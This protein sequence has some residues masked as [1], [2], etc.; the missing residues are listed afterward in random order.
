M[1]WDGEHC[2]PKTTGL[3]PIQS[4]CRKFLNCFKGRGHVQSCAPG[5]LFNS[6]SLECDFPAKVQ[7]SDGTPS[8][9]DSSYINR[10]PS[11]TFDLNA[12]NSDQ[13]QV[14]ISN[15]N[16]Y[17]PQ[18]SSNSLVGTQFIVGGQQSST[19]GYFQNFDSAVTID[20]GL[21]SGGSYPPLYGSSSVV[22]GYR[23][24]N[25]ESQS[26]QTS[27]FAANE[28][29]P[30]T[31]SQ[32]QQNPDFAVNG[33]SQPNSFVQPQQYPPI[34]NPDFSVNGH[35]QPNTF[36]QPQQY[37]DSTVNGY[38][39]S[40]TVLQHQQFSAEQNP[41]FFPQNT[42]NRQLN[43]N[44]PTNTR[45]VNSNS[46]YGG[47]TPTFPVGQTF[48]QNPQNTYPTGYVYSGKDSIPATLNSQSNNQNQNNESPNNYG[49]PNNYETPNNYG[50]SNNNG[51]VRENQNT[52]LNEQEQ[53]NQQKN[54]LRFPYPKGTAPISQTGYTANKPS[55]PS[56]INPNSWM[57]GQLKEKQ[58]LGHSSNSLNNKQSENEEFPSSNNQFNK[59]SSTFDLGNRQPT[60]NENRQIHTE[61]NY[62]SSI[63]TSQSYV[64]SEQLPYIPNG[65]G[66]NS[67]SPSP[68]NTAQNS[69]STPQDRRIHGDFK[70]NKQFKVI[71]PNITYPNN[72]NEPS[73]YQSNAKPP[74]E[75][76]FN[77]GSSG[78]KLSN[79]YGSVQN[80]N[81]NEKSSAIQNPIYIDQN[82][83]PSQETLAIY[84]SP[85][86]VSNCPNN[87]NG[88]KPHPTDCSK[89]LSCANGRTFEMNCGPGTLFNPT[90]SVCDHPYN[91][92]CNN[93]FINQDATTETTIPTQ[94]YTPVDNYTP[95]I[96]LRQQFNDQD[97]SSSVLVPKTAEPLESQAVLETLPNENKQLKVLRN[98]E[99]IDLVDNFLSN[100]SVIQTPSKTINNK[101][102]NNIAVRI[103]LKPNSTQS[104]RL[105]GGPK[106]SEGFLQIQE[107]PFQWGVVCDEPNS[108]TIDKADII[109]KQLGFK[110]Y[111]LF[112]LL[113]MY[114]YD[115]KLTICI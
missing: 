11:Q 28:Y 36:I 88:I 105:R 22:N 10:N 87:F 1:S 69:Y 91:V 80:P 98:P 78:K 51:Y 111:I 67:N 100:T 40:S 52:Y 16:Q 5:T 106:H 15:S 108:W 49:T 2:P 92:Q 63:G 77:R 24:S 94:N 54:K 115:E 110:R 102:E 64:D 45:P 72:N 84:S 113:N 56:N 17:Q 58:K 20:Y 107:K 21:Q 60:E 61:N 89:F 50:P 68:D 34:Q 46:N 30:N 32:Y 76:Y 27:N 53:T 79:S 71:V 8:K 37:S 95:D 18:A 31:G 90:I 74:K 19:D 7:C 14:F 82:Q 13:D 112:L 41:N 59:P 86:V 29:Q 43:P 83:S 57:R 66:Y 96:D 62:D 4:D 114:I 26:Q 97:S 99:S 104:I 33:Y 6:N 48:N 103:D 38:T 101:V 93:Q 44:L 39:Q 109:C 85:K 47:S 75:F 23:Q 3:F 12:Q 9:I 35:A 81:Q 55:N 73:S 70:M 25:T 42:Y 65:Q